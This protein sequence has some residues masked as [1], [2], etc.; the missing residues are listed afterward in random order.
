MRLTYDPEKFQLNTIHA[1]I[2]GSSYEI[3][4]DPQKALALRAEF[5]QTK[6]IAQSWR[7]AICA[8][9][10]YSDVQKG[11]LA[12][13]KQL[14][15]EDVFHFTH[16]DDIICHILFHGTIHLTHEYKKQQLAQKTEELV[17]A[18]FSR[19]IDPQ[20]GHPVPIDRIRSAFTQLKLKIH[21]QKSTQDQ[22]DAI[23][24]RL[25]SVFPIQLRI[26]TISTQNHQSHTQS[27]NN[28]SQTNQTHSTNK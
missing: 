13:T 26:A 17:H 25:Q 10:V 3:V 19:C 28:Q 7:S 11:L 1:I 4:V 16:V 24:T 18:V 9:H 5:A 20:T 6:H 2:L 12:S 27:H 14:L 8:W 23:I 22:V 15:N 21:E